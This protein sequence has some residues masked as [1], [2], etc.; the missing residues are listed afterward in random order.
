L[1]HTP[2]ITLRINNV[3]GDDV[4]SHVVI[5]NQVKGNKIVI[6]SSDKDFYQL[7]DS[8]TQIWDPIKKI[9]IT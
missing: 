4:I 3:E 7:V 5:E 6:C 8:N 2:I 1:K 9:Y